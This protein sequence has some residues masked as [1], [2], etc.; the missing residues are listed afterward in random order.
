MGAVAGIASRGCAAVKRRQQ[1]TGRRWP[2]D[3]SERRTS[4]DEQA[5]DFPDSRLH[6][7]TCHRLLARM[8]AHFPDFPDSRLAFAGVGAARD[9]R[10]AEKRPAPAD[11]ARANAA[12]AFNG[13]GPFRG[14][15]DT[16]ANWREAVPAG[17]RRQSELPDEPS[18]HE[19]NDMR[20]SGGRVLPRG[21][22]HGC[23]SSPRLRQ[24]EILGSGER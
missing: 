7:P 16:G 17:G 24:F 10:Q 6:F 5:G 11:L 21:S 12:P 13:A 14:V 18:E 1:A 2:V 8:D 23:V 22:G 20:S 3:K 15:R 9:R 4:A 19:V